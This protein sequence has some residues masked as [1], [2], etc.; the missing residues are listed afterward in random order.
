[1]VTNLLKQNVVHETFKEQFLI[2]SQLKTAKTN[3]KLCNLLKWQRGGG[4]RSYQL[5]L[6]EP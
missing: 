2:S 5:W 6:I 3:N 4:S 1:M